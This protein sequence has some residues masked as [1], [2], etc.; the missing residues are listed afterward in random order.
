MERRSEQAGRR[1]ARTAGALAPSARHVRARVSVRSETARVDAS[2]RA[3]HAAVPRSRRTG[4]GGRGAG[5]GAE[6]G[7]ATP[8]AVRAKNKHAVREVRPIRSPMYVCTPHASAARTSRKRRAGLARVVYRTHLASATSPRSR[9]RRSRFRFGASRARRRRPSA[10]CGYDRPHPRRRRASHQAPVVGRDRERFVFRFSTPPPRRASVVVRPRRRRVPGTSKSATS[11]PPSLR[12]RSRRR[13]SRTAS[14]TLA[15]RV[16]ARAVLGHRGVRPRGTKSIG[17][18]HHPPGRT[19]SEPHLLALAHRVPSPRLRIAVALRP[20]SA[21]RRSSSF[22][23]RL[24]AEP[25]LEV[26]SPPVTVNA[27]VSCARA[28]R[29]RAAGPRSGPGAPSTGR[30]RRRPRRPVWGRRFPAPFSV[31][32]TRTCHADEGYPRL[33]VPGG[34]HGL[35]LGPRGQTGH[36]DWHLL[37]PGV[38]TVEQ[39]RSHGFPCDT[40]S[41]Y[42]PRG[43]RGRRCLSA[44]GL[45]FC[46]ARRVMLAPRARASPSGETA[47]DGLAARRHTASPG[48]TAMRGDGGALDAVCAIVAVLGRCFRW[49][50][51]FLRLESA[52]SIATGRRSVRHAL[53]AGS[54]RA[55]IR[56]GRGRRRASRCDAPIGAVARA[57]GRLAVMRCR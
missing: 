33:G 16:G 55:D 56:N 23:A 37:M 5:G 8:A 11:E 40:G 34:N 57:R 9:R 43:C 51:R 32:H 47:A 39:P 35:E 13:A 30:T 22:R 15:I 45:S 6:N 12:R 28:P 10:I 14:R 44:G 7:A 1:R 41:C 29:P 31:T 50:T 17:F 3:E 21:P 49:P 18:G 2:R 20:P 27:N 42:T 48:R 52:A 24:S 36:R 19:R 26:E 46:V 4:S 38:S 53:A 54:P 25:S